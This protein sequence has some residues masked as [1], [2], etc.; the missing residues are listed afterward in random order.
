MRAGA[1][2]A[3]RHRRE[4]TKRACALRYRRAQACTSTGRESTVAQNNPQNESVADLEAELAASRERLAR[5]IDEIV[6]RAQP[7]TIVESL[8][9][10]T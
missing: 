4:S 10:T 5:N 3:L 8:R 9:P 2:V 1:R 7:K 6:Y